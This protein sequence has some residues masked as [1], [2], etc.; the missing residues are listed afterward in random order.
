MKVRLATVEDYD[1]IMTLLKKYHA[2]Y[3]DE[4]D[5]KDGFVTTNFT[6]EQLKSLIKDE[7][8][9]IVA[10]DDEGE[11]V[12]YATA[13]PWSF[14]LQWPLFELMVSI[15]PENPFEGN[16]LTVENSYQYGPV[17]V[18]KKYRGTGLFEEVFK[19]SLDSM[20]DRYPYMVTFINKINPRSYAAH[21]DKVHMT[22]IGGFQFNNNN[23]YLMACNTK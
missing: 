15:L 4:E 9:V 22:E 23:Y 21:T 10:E 12:S 5:K 8:G 2:N 19:A 17:C 14:W 18:D 16:E 11:I 6:E 1:G 20:S 13:A 3:M 7:H